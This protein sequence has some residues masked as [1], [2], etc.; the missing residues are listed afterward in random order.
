[1]RI[2][3]DGDGVL[4]NLEDYQLKYGKEYFTDVK[5]IDETGY[6]IVVKKKEKNSGL[7]IYGDIV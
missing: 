6:D 5:D 4:T 1:M 7:N 2:A 3:F